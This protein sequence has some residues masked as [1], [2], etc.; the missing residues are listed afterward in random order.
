MNKKE[1]EDKL[2][3][4]YINTLENQSYIFDDDIFYLEDVFDLS[5]IINLN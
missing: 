4:E 2:N 3:Y 1:K 5:D